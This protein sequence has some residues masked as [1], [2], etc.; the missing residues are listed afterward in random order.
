MKTEL[1]ADQIID[2]LGGTSE[3]ARLCEISPQATCQWRTKGIPK[4]WM[5]FLRAERPDVFEPKPAAAPEHSA[6]PTP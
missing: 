2:A 1:T 6:A 5:K 4:P 3:I